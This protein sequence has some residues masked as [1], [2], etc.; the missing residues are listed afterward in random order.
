MNKMLCYIHNIFINC[1]SKKDTNQQVL[2][3]SQQ[4][5]LKQGVGKLALRPHEFIKSMWNKEE[6]SVEWKELIIVPIYKKGYKTDCSNYKGIS[7]LSST[8]KIL[9]NVLPSRLTPYAREITG[10]HQCGF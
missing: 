3:T 9:P 6:L 4:N 1:C 10:G 8:Y 7:L 2:I 5:W